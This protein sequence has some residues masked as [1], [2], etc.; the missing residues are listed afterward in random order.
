MVGTLLDDDEEIWMRRPLKTLIARATVLPIPMALDKFSRTCAP[1]GE[2]A[3]DIMTTS[4]SSRL[5]LGSLTLNRRLSSCCCRMWTAL[6]ALVQFPSCCSRYP[7]VLGRIW[8]VIQLHL[9][10]GRCFS[11]SISILEPPTAEAALGPRVTE[12]LLSFITRRTVEFKACINETGSL[13]HSDLVI[14]TSWP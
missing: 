9:K 5:R 11:Q 14:I 13:A 12:N 8:V 1:P 4:L 6:F 2:A 3:H 10:T 7:H